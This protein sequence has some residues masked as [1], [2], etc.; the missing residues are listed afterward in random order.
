[1]KLVIAALAVLCVNAAADAE[2]L[3]WVLAPNGWQSEFSF[4]RIDTRQAFGADG[5]RQRLF[6]PYSR[7]GDG[8]YASNVVRGEV[9]FGASEDFTLLGV[10]SF[11]QANS[12]YA[13]TLLV[14]R[15]NSGLGDIY[16]AGIY[17]LTR[18][19]FA[20]SL[21]VG[22]KIPAA[23]TG[24]ATAVALG[25]GTMDFDAIASAGWAPTFDVV[26]PRLSASVGYRFSGGDLANKILYSAAA[27]GW[28]AHRVLALRLALDGTETTGDVRTPSPSSN[29]ATFGIVMN[30]ASTAASIGARAQ[31]SPR[32]RLGVDWSTVLAGKNA[33]AGNTIAIGVLLTPPQATPI[34]P[35]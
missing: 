25:T 8:E 31:L 3:A 24:S 7:Q 19:E 5:T 12:Q 13:D 10:V 22:W 16:F 33:F 29:S 14:Q 11:H 18:G 26:S 1:M 15:P 28:F 6:A 2:D 34:A 20:S 9:R 32:V 35:K 23:D 27:E 21:T 17:A 30:T 4:S